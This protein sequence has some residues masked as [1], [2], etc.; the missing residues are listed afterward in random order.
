MSRL[1]EAVAAARWA[2]SRTW[3]DAR[4]LCGV[5]LGSALVAAVVP[6]ASALV[7]GATVQSLRSGGLD[8]AGVSRTL[9]LFGVFVL[10]ALAESVASALRAFADNRI[11]DELNVELNVDLLRKAGELDL[12][13][14]E[15]S[16]SQ[17]MLSRASKVPGR[18]FTRLLGAS[19]DALQTIVRSVT[20][21]GVLFWIQA[22]WAAVLVVAALPFVKYRLSAARDRFELERLRTTKRRWSNYYRSHMTS[23]GLVSAT[24]IQDL[25]SLFIGR[26]RETLGEIVASLAV[27]HRRQA[28]GVLVAQI[29][30]LTALTAAVSSMLLRD[31]GSTL[32]VGEFAAFGLAAVRLRG[33]YQ[34]LASAIAGAFES[35]LYSTYLLDFM[36]SSPSISESGSGHG[37]RIAGAIELREVSFTYP[38]TKRPALDKVSLRIA[39]GQT[40]ALVGHNGS[41]K[42]TLARL[43][44]RLYRPTAGEILVDGQHVTDWDLRAYHDQLALLSQGPVAYEATAAE[45]LAF[46]D[47]EALGRDREAIE[48]LVER[49]SIDDIVAR[50]PEGLDTHLGRRFGSVTLSAGL[51]QRLAIA[52]ALGRRPAILILDEPTSNLDVSAE[53]RIFSAIRDLAAGVT[54]LLISHRF[55][56]VRMADRIFVLEGGRLAEQG[57][58]GEL[59]GQAGLYATLYRMHLAALGAVEEPS[60]VRV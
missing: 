8:S 33:A 22:F 32:M 18:P 7:L 60:E 25:G 47:W 39:A 48:R 29:V 17:D 50:L 31:L 14:F 19:V 34:G 46:G 53:A 45:N 16:D 6:A 55:S 1:V 38:R 26:F 56:T 42:T 4:F 9:L 37:E 20:L 24:K 35:S 11:A 23:P 49:T 21:L 40:V 57:S 52:R 44:A 5:L 10:L 51:W 15:D 3:K 2:L 54:T 36:A 43:L 27:V 13:F 58:H 28:V 59:M 41:G 12:A 30:F